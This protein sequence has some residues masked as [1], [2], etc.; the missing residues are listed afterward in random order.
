MWTSTVLQTGGRHNMAKNLRRDS[1]VRYEGDL[2]ED[3]DRD[4]IVLAVI[5]DAS[6]DQIATVEFGP[7]RLQDIPASE[8]NRD[9][10]TARYFD[11][12][13]IPVD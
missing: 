5:D 7:G 8:L 11:D 2:P 4:G 9:P 1:R 12:D 13:G 3:W 10:V 6:G